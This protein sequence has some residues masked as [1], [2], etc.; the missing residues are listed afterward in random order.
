[1]AEA[2]RIDL[3]EERIEAPAP[4]EYPMAWHRFLSCFLLC[5]AAALRLGQAAWLLLGGA[6][7]SR[8]LQSQIYEG[9]PALKYA[10]WAWAACMAIA[11]VLLAR[12]ARRLRARRHCGLTLLKWGWLLSAGA[13][14]AHMLARFAISGLPPLNL[15]ELARLLAQLLLARICTVYY[16]RRPGALD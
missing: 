12:S 5:G 10:D 1:M 8:A 14:A 6:Y 2:I 11:A 3:L 9:L 4:P 15:S 7:R 13:G 16:R